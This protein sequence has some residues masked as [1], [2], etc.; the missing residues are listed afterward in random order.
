MIN[1]VN[2]LLHSA[3]LKNFSDT[4]IE[5]KATINY[6]FETN[7]LVILD[8]IEEKRVDTINNFDLV[9][10]VDVDSGRSK[11]IKTK[12]R[13]LVDYIK[14]LSNNVLLV[15]NVSDD[16]SNRESILDLYTDIKELDDS[17]YRFLVQVRDPIL[18]NIEINELIVLSTDKDVYTLQ[19]GSLS[20]TGETFGELE[21]S[22][23]QFD[24][25]SLR[26]LI[27]FR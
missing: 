17:Y 15:D 7:D 21:G 2:R 23:D 3:G 12:N 11:F 20:T 9:V 5:S 13:R 25:K 4:Q 16:F 14:C 26:L 19:K 24:T 22:I 8:V 6:N 18:G 1:P 10:D 27:L